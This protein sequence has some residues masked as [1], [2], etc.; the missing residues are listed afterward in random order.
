ML[1]EARGLTTNLSATVEG[2]LGTFVAQEKARRRD[3]E[4]RLERV[5]DA[6]N[7]FHEEHG[8]LSDEFPSF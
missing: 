6:L 4:A 1:A 8:F 3:E 5:I 2:L 7:E